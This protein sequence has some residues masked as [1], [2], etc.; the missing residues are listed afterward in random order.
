MGGGFQ[1]ARK[2]REITFYDVIEPIDHVSR[3]E[4]CIMGKKSCSSDSP[5]ALHNKW[6][7]VR[8]TYLVMLKESTLADAT[9]SH[10]ELP[11]TLT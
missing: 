2:P 6:E 5:C 8:E 3:W 9:N 7:K 4:G 11:V 10:L 1:L